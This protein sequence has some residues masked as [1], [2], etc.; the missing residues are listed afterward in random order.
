MP[1][2]PAGLYS[3]VAS[4]FAQPG[5]TIRTE[6]HNPVFED[7][8]AA[9]S[10]VLLRDGR[11]PMTGPL[12]M[13]G[14]PINNITAGN[15]S[16]SVATLAQTVPIGGIVD[17]AGT[18]APAGWMLCYGQAISRTT[19]AQLFALLSTGYGPG[20]GSTTF[21][22]PDLRGFVVAGKDNMGGAAAGRLTIIAG[23]TL[24]TQGGTETVTLTAAQLAKHRHTGLTNGMSR[25]NP[26]GHPIVASKG[27]LGVVVYI[28]TTT[29]FEGVKPGSGVID[30]ASLSVGNTDIDHEHGF[31]TDEGTGVNGEAHSNV[32]P[33]IILNKIIKVSYDD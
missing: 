28:G 24:G 19:Y 5:T 23:G 14:N 26:H 6:Q 3:L 7:V 21:N 10:S 13:N 15:S 29:T 22:L 30:L 20:D 32:Q 2:N 4:Y 25:N 18:S 17:F 1:Y 31:T 12:N 11:A 33:T 8:G 9:L 27:N 16:G